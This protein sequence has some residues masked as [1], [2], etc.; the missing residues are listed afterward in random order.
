METYTTSTRSIEN[1]FPGLRSF[2]PDEYA[3]FFGRETHIQ[4]VTQK[5]MHNRFVAVIGSSGVGKSS[6]I[7]CGLLP[8]LRNK[9]PAENQLDWDIKN[10]QPSELPYSNLLEVLGLSPDTDDR[11]SMIALLKHQQ[12]ENPTN[13]LLFFDHFEEYFRGKQNNTQNRQEL[14][15][16]IELLLELSKEPALSLYVVITMR[17]DFLGYCSY[18]PEFTKKMNDSQF[19]IPFMTRAEQREAIIGP[20]EYMDAS[21][22][23]EL[24]ERV[25]DDVKDIPDQLPLM[26]HALMRTWNEWQKYRY[27]DPSLRLVHYENIGGVAQALSV[28]ANEAYNELPPEQKNTCAKVFRTITEV[29]NDGK[30]I[31]RPAQIQQIAAEVNVTEQEVIN[32]IAPFRQKDRGL[33]LPSEDEVSTLNGS[34]AIE[35][36]H[37]SLIRVWTTL[38]TWVEEEVN[39]VKLYQRLADDAERFQKEQTGHWTNPDLEIALDWRNKQKPTKAWGTRYHPTFDRTMWFLQS[40]KEAHDQLITNQEQKR[41]RDRRRAAFVFRLIL[42]AL[43]FAIILAG[44]AWVQS[45]EA[46]KQG[47][48]AKEKGVIAE[49]AAK[50]AKREAERAT[51]ESKKAEAASKKAE[52]EAKNA[53]EQKKLAD[54]EKEKAELSAKAAAIAETIAKKKAQEAKTAEEKARKEAE[55][56][57]L[58]KE[59]ADIEKQLADLAR[60][61]AD[62]L[63]MRSIASSM[64]I[65]SLELSPDPELEALVAE[66][67]YKFHKRSG[68]D[69]NH[70]DLYNGLYYALKGVKGSDYNQLKGHGANVRALVGGK[71]TQVYSAGSD[72]KIMLWDITSKNILQAYPQTGGLGIHRALAL[73]PSKNYLACVGNYPEVWLFPDGNLQV[74]PEKI[75]IDNRLVGQIWFVTFIDNQKMIFADEGGNLHLGDTQSKTSKIIQSQLGQVNAI[76]ASKGI[77]AFTNGSTVKL[78]KG[79]YT[80]AE[81]FPTS[82]LGQIISLALS[83]DANYLALGDANGLVQV[84]YTQSKTLKGITLRGHTARINQMAFSKDATQLATGSFDKS[85]RIWNIK[86]MQDFDRPPII[87]KDHNDWVWSIT[88]SADG[89]KL[90]AG[91]RDNVVR[92]WPT[93]LEAMSQEICPNVQRNMTRKEWERFVSP[94]KDAAQ[95]ANS[96]GDK[97]ADTSI[98]YEKTCEQYGLGELVTEDDLR[99]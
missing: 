43:V 56:A 70:P 27:R 44:Y 26:Q 35:I 67:A 21:I 66:Q 11:A 78:L 81:T 89:S 62:R 46:V 98:P 50:E 91:C 63:R 83:E 30:C 45:Q 94:L 3:L 73:S 88:F 24:V 96:K 48:I 57:Q 80:Q 42:A 97:K 18:Y 6:F 33:L 10:I 20:I 19:L 65:K 38:N 77:V 47:K 93:S 28:H 36:S 9:N 71:N 2:R 23:E 60:Q 85:V 68:G 29:T 75:T 79:D 76:A 15:K 84:Y 22:E 39:S 4:E 49:K 32:V 90:L 74:Q 34:S 95:Q 99:K 8:I 7:Y 41:Q 12:E 31:K 1:P 52:K 54:I 87:L 59:L 69:P 14:D 13:T 37:E 40:S 25:L 58:N 53:L 51:E 61:E 82:G 17:S 92:A 55:I 64:A 72:G 5:L 86:T 16:L